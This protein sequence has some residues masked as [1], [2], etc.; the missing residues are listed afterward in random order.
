MHAVRRKAHPATKDGALNYNP[1]ARVRPQK[2]VPRE[3]EDTLHC[4][5]SEDFGAPEG[6]AYEGDHR[7]GIFMVMKPDMQP[8]A[9]NMVGDYDSSKTGSVRS[10]D[11]GQTLRVVQS[12][13]TEDL[14]THPSVGNGTRQRSATRTTLGV[15]SETATTWMRKE[16]EG[17]ERE[18]YIYYEKKFFSVVPGYSEEEVMR[19]VYG[20]SD[21]KATPMNTCSEQREEYELSAQ[22]SAVASCISLSITVICLM[23]ILGQEL[24]EKLK[25]VVNRPQSVFT[26]L[27]L[28]TTS[29]AV[30]L[31]RVLAMTL[32]TAKTIA[33]PIL[34]SPPPSLGQLLV[35]DT[36]FD[37]VVDALV[38]AYLIAMSL[39][40]WYGKGKEAKTISLI[41]MLL[42]ALFWLAII[43][44]SFAAGIYKTVLKICAAATFHFVSTDCLQA[45]NPKA[46]LLRNLG[47]S[48]FLE[49]IGMAMQQFSTSSILKALP[50]ALALAAFSNWLLPQYPSR[51]SSGQQ[52]FHLRDTLRRDG[53]PYGANNRAFPDVPQSSAL[54]GTSVHRESARRD[55]D[56]TTVPAGQTSG[57]I[58]IHAR[59]SLPDPDAFVIGDD[60]DDLA[61]LRSGERPL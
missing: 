48:A 45:A 38:V 33:A 28:V 53:V 40:H 4:T 32:L 58:S 50:L 16:L 43:S 30:G 42:M 61:S 8:Q 21:S 51:Q 44:D 52:R 27:P 2:Q 36:W 47:I 60:T 13:A 15:L 29:G 1:F 5:R 35:D 9:V 37:F 56:E 46:H 41:L 25:K 11:T 34:E 14:P 22:S 19:I 57:R 23:V 59:E 10:S 26:S 54:G 3:D 31:L 7:V 17:L 24:W 20:H 6:L 12:D 55:Q 39:S 18:I 49:F